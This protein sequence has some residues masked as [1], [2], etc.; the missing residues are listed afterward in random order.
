MWGYPRHGCI[1]ATDGVSKH[2]GDVCVLKH[3]GV[4]IDNFT[5]DQR[6]SFGADTTDSSGEGTVATNNVMWQ[7]AS[8]GAW[9]CEALNKLGWIIL[10][11]QVL[12]HDIA[13]APRT[14]LGWSGR[15]TWPC[16]T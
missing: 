10:A 3:L 15:W 7:I 5:G 13:Q 12:A 4:L 9:R 6:L 1:I 8:V 16:L 11:N 2:V 14:C